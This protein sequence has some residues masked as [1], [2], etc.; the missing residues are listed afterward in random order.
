MT[1]PFSAWGMLAARPRVDLRQMA[2]AKIDEA[3]ASRLSGIFD[4]LELEAVAYFG[5]ASRHELVLTHTVESRYRNQE[6]SVAFECPPSAP[7]SEIMK[8]MHAA[9]KEAFT[10]DLPD[11]EAEI[12]TVHLQAEA[13]VETV[14]LSRT[15]AKSGNPPIPDRCRRIFLGSAGGWIDCDVYLRE[16]IVPGHNLRG[17]ALVEES[18]TTTLVLPDQILAMDPTGQLIIREQA[19]C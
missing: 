16:G 18:T 4:Q 7:P 3:L 15:E 5:V 13:L 12:T 11:A 2:F 10:F 6:H 19:I 14:P 9:H 17:P 8:R 1:P